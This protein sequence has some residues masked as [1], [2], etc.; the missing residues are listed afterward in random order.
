VLVGWLLVRL[1][2]CG[3]T[4]GQIDMPLGM[5]KLRLSDEGQKLLSIFE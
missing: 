2:I 3:Q 4:A 1:M 5:A